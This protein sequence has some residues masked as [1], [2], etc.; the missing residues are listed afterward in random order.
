[1]VFV[2]RSLPIS[3]RLMVLSSPCASSSIRNDRKWVTKTAW[4]MRL[5]HFRR[6]STFANPRFQATFM[7]CARAISFLW[8]PGSDHTKVYECRSENFT[9]EWI[10]LICGRYFA[11]CHCFGVVHRTNTYWMRVRI[12]SQPNLCLLKVGPCKG[13]FGTAFAAY[14][15]N[16]YLTLVFLQIWANSKA[17]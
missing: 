10:L 13:F 7:V 5:R 17:L 3:V 8:G 15:P 11:F 2:K 16:I 14:L 1:V 6:K 4:H 12:F 9:K